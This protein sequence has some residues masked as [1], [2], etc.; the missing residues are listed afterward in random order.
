MLPKFSG[1]EKLTVK[2]VERSNC[3]VLVVTL[4]W[5]TNHGQTK[6]KQWKLLNI[7]QAR[8]GEVPEAENAYIQSA[9]RRLPHFDG[10]SDQTCIQ[11]DDSIRAIFNKDFGASSIDD[12]IAIPAALNVYKQNTKR[13]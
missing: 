4:T 3:K 8:P 2:L 1:E 13:C 9:V 5:C 12:V 6:Q 11:R 10:R 7:N